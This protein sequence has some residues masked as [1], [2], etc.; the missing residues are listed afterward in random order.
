[1][2]FSENFIK[3]NYFSHKV[4]TQRYKNNLIYKITKIKRGKSS[5]KEHFEG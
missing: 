5:E 2:I 1:V 3:K 4:I